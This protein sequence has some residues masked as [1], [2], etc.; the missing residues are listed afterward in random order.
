MRVLLNILM[1]LVALP[2]YGWTL[3]G[4]GDGNTNLVEAFYPT[5]TAMPRTRDG[6]GW[7][8]AKDI[9]VTD[10]AYA[11]VERVYYSQNAPSPE[12]IL[13]GIH[14]D[15]YK[16]E[17]EALEVLKQVLR[18]LV[19]DGVY[20]DLSLRTNGTYIGWL[21]GQS[22]TSLIDG[23][24]PAPKIPTFTT[25]SILEYVGLP[26]DWWTNTPVRFLGAIG[27]PLA[28]RVDGTNEWTTVDYGW[29]GFFKVLGAL[30]DLEIQ[31][32]VW[33][34][35]IGAEYEQECDG[36][37]EFPFTNKFSS[38]SSGFGMRSKP[39]GGGERVGVRFTFENHPTIT[40]WSPMS[41]TESTERKASAIPVG[42]RPSID[43]TLSEG[44]ANAFFQSYRADAMV[45]RPDNFGV[46]MIHD[47]EYIESFRGGYNYSECT[48]GI[49]FFEDQIVLEGEPGY[50]NFFPWILEA[51]LSAEAVVSEDSI[52]P[53]GSGE[54]ES[55]EVYRLG[56]ALLPP[57]PPS[58]SGF[59]LSFLP[60][61]NEFLDV[62]GCYFFEEYSAALMATGC[63]DGDGEGLI[64]LSMEQTRL[65]DPSTGDPYQ[66]RRSTFIHVFQPE[67]AYDV[68]DI[69]GE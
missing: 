66:E 22:V 27:E 47:E 25:N 19:N 60:D 39:V 24:V 14:I 1:L 40:S 2:C 8:F 64:S 55:P 6:E 15:E 3:N 61:L 65:R 59:D 50:T 34:D 33:G 45:V 11:L 52:G 67:F 54:N 56:P 10:A 62:S 32:A 53:F 5:T 69:L 4:W 17:N 36:L 68:T 41:W 42:W 18:S 20:L 48:T 23:G 28:V 58:V 49:W 16:F 35:D 29:E 30:Q 31:P 21:S 9:W 63:I 12:D 7:A 13:E 57:P 43:Y 38:M 26:M 51:N 37:L 44:L 46:I